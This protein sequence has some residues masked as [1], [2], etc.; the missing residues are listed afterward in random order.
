MCSRDQLCA[1]ET[2]SDIHGENHEKRSDQQMYEN[3][4]ESQAE[5]KKHING[6]WRK[7]LFYQFPHFQTSKE[8]SYLII[9]LIMVRQNF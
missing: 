6:I 9:I 7:S 1:A 3:Y 2:Y 4:L 8:L 5:E